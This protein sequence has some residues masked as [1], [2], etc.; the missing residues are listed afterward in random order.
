MDRFAIAGCTAAVAG[1]ESWVEEGTW[2]HADARIMNADDLVE[3]ACRRA[4]SDDFGDETWREGLDVL[5]DSLRSEAALNELGDS[6][7]TDQ[8][9]GLLV[10]RLEVEQWFARHPEI[11]EQE[12]SAPL[13]GLGLPRTGSTALSFLLASDPARRSLRTWEAAKP[14]P[15]PEAATEHTDPRIAETQVGIDMT[16]E[17]FPDFVGMLPTSATGPQ[18]CILLMALDFRSQVFEG[19]ARI[20]SYSAWLLECD[21]EPAYRYHRRVLQLLQW[22]CPPTRWWL[23]TPAHMHSIDALDRIYPDARFVMT[24]RDVGKVLPSV[25]AVFEALSDVLTQR[26]DPIAIGAHNAELWRYSL[27]RLIEFRDAGNGD[28]FF[29]V[30]FEAVQRDPMAAVARLY[31]ELGDELSEDARTRMKGWWAESSKERSGPHTYRAETFGLDPATIR[32]QFAFY[33]D[34]FDVPLEEPGTA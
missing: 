22:R 30:S 3:T 15:P 12:I 20:P 9:L 34:R 14:C 18:E 16:N 23:K 33:Y 29:D 6:V 19:M 1:L 13:F 7:M 31:E 27:E 32:E 28:R 11:A 4:G 26:P 5:V 24:H 2:L 25:C 8:V 17:M 10:N 21:M